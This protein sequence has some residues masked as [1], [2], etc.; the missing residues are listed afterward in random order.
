MLNILKIRMPFWCA[1]A[2]HRESMCCSPTSHPCARPVW[3]T[4]LTPANASELSLTQHNNSRLFFI[5]N[6]YETCRQKN[7]QKCLALL[8]RNT[9]FICRKETWQHST[10]EKNPFRAQRC[11]RSFQKPNT[12]TEGSVPQHRRGSFEGLW[13]ARVVKLFVQGMNT[14]FWV[15]CVSQGPQDNC[16]SNLRSFSLWWSSLSV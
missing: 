15:E 12:H 4:T 3:N 8:Y 5:F 6:E 7:P 14:G 11:S 9:T 2:W 16:C 1:D 13:T 10:N